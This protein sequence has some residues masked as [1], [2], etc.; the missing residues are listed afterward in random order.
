MTP[1]AAGGRLPTGPVRTAR[2]P[3]P[4]PRFRLDHRTAGL[5]RPI[6]AVLAVAL[7]LASCSGAAPAS[8]APVELTVFAAASLR[9][10]FTQ[11]APMF[12]A[13]RPGVQLIFSF[14]A[15]S[16]LRTQIEQGAPADAFAS[17]DEQNPRVLAD[18]GL[19]VGPPSAFAG[20]ELAVIVA[21]G[22]PAR[23]ATPA[24]LARPGVRIVAAGHAVP[25]STYADQLVANLARRPGYPSDFAAKVAANAVSRE[26]NVRGILTKIELGEGDAGIVYATDARSSG[27]VDTIPIPDGANVVATYA[28]VAIRASTHPAEARSFVDFLGSPGAQAVLEALGFVRAR[29]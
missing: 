23:I 28:A 26:D 21:P 15:S 2:L 10:A 6:A 5:R 9:T 29:R 24:D 13:N 7:A 4:G 20:N 27:R 19:A 25:V 16:T 18:A 14:D 1:A 12:E 8:R 11:L 22:N 17:A 3:G